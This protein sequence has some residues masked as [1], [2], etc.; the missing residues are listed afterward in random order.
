VD[1]W[2]NIVINLYAMFDDDWLWNQKV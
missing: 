2:P 1:L